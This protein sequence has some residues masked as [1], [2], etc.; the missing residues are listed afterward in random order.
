MNPMKRIRNA[1]F[2]LM[3]LASCV[4]VQIA[5]TITME[6]DLFRSKNWNVAVVDFDY[7]YENEGSLNGTNYKSAGKD[8]GKVLADLF[9]AELSRLKNVTILE[10]S[11]ISAVL[12]E[13]ALQQSGVTDPGSAAELG[14]LVGADAVVTGVVTD[15]VYWSSLTGSGT[16][17]S[18]SIKMVDVRTGKVMLNGSISRA[19]NLTD[20]FPNAQMT[21]KDL[22]DAIQN[23]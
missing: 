15:Y 17:V 2:P 16:T 1:L 3:M 12:K 4:P 19:R 11:K 22:V 6:K 13:Q 8:G 14:K 10:R 23:Y 21:T 5:P 7:E 9:S 20:A 18:F